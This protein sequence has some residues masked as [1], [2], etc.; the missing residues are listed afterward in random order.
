[1]FIIFVLKNYQLEIDFR[2]DFNSS[3]EFSDDKH[4]GNLEV[5]GDRERWT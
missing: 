5:L 1:M 2:I 3:E 4:V